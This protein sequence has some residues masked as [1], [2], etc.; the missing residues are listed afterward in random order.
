MWQEVAIRELAVLI[1]I[2]VEASGQTFLCETKKIIPFIDKLLTAIQYKKDDENSVDL[3]NRIMNL[4]SKLSR[5]LN[6]VQ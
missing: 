3:V 4:M 2:S 6:G 5:D 1:N